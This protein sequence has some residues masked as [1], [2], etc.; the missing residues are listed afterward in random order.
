MQDCQRKGKGT[1]TISLCNLAAKLPKPV[2]DLHQNVFDSMFRWCSTFKD[3]NLLCM[4]P[5]SRGGKNLKIHLLIFAKLLLDWQTSDSFILLY[6]FWGKN[7]T[8]RNTVSKRK[9]RILEESQLFSTLPIWK[10][11]NDL[12]KSTAKYFW[13]RLQE[14]QMA[15]FRSSYSPHPT[16]WLNS[17]KKLLFSIRNPTSDH[18]NISTTFCLICLQSSNKISH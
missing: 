8:H 10:W 14:L 18:S 6:Y 15:L 4:S 16:G 7:A 3:Y 17:I 12:M 5:C 9:D 11:H 13:G 1:A 2:T